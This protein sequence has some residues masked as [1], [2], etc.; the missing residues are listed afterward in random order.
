MESQIGKQD[1][2][3]TVRFILWFE[4]FDLWRIRRTIKK[5]EATGYELAQ[6][7]PPGF[8]GPQRLSMCF[9]RSPQVSPT[10]VSLYWGRPVLTMQPT[11]VVKDTFATFVFVKDNEDRTTA[12]SAT[13]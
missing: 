8:P 4:P 1:V 3:V 6:V 13:P 5:Y 10:Q 12:S 11:W 2:Q 9:T 7:T